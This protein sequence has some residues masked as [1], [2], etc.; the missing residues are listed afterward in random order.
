MQK[1]LEKL[2]SK[3]D[4][5]KEHLDSRNNCIAQMDFAEFFC[6]SDELAPYTQEL[7]ERGKISPLV[8]QQLYNDHL[9]AP[10]LREPAPHGITLPKFYTKEI[11]K[12]YR[13]HEKFSKMIHDEYDLTPHNP[14]EIRFN[15]NN[16]FIKSIN[17]DI[18]DL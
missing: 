17:I 1:I 6:V 8:L 9:I 16:R 5:I 13:L 2:K 18:N 11:E 15:P 7:I 14:E 3:L 12:S 10:R 4:F